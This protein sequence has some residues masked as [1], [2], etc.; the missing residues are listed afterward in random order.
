MK[1]N[2]FFCV[3][4]ALTSGVLSQNV[5]VAD[6]MEKVPLP[7]AFRPYFPTISQS[8]SGML[9][10]KPLVLPDAMQFQKQYSDVDWKYFFGHLETGVSGRILDLFGAATRSSTGAA[11]L[12]ISSFRLHDTAV[13]RQDVPIMTMNAGFGFN[14]G[15]FP[16]FLGA[17]YAPPPTDTSYLFDMRQTNALLALPGPLAR[18]SVDIRFEYVPG[19]F[20]SQGLGAVVGAL[21]ARY[22]LR[23]VD[24]TSNTTVSL[25]LRDERG[26]VFQGASGS[27]SS[28][29]DVLADKKTGEG[30][31]E[32]SNPRLRVLSGTVQYQNELVRVIGGN[33]FMDH[34]LVMF[35]LTNPRSANEPLYTGVWISFWLNDRRTVTLYT[36]FNKVPAGTTNIQ[37][38]SGWAYPGTVNNTFGTVFYPWSKV[39]ESFDVSL[40]DKL[41]GKNEFSVSPMG[42]PN[43]NRVRLWTSPITGKRFGT[44]YKV[45]IRTRARYLSRLQQSDSRGEE[46]YDDETRDVLETF[47]LKPLSENGEIYS[48]NPADTANSFFETGVSVFRS[49]NFNGAPIGR[50]VLEQFGNN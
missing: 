40:E 45:T 30:S 37:A 8:P 13:G 46:E 15:Q 39:S 43:P 32:Y 4:L 10:R 14:A 9:P 6:V 20:A 35:D 31:L 42:S 34:Q 22:R 27:V 38:L 25:E 44:T 36:K 16:A 28:T 23:M 12:I 17:L 49:P 2:V 47:Y 29:L 50:G 41:V 1:L 21:G 19:P 11:D 7:D 26:T 33:V 3:T 5:P 24:R 48:T 18:D